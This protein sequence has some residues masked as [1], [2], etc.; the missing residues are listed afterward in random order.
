MRIIK[1]AD[2]NEVSKKAAEI[3]RSQVILKPESVLGL[4]TGSTPLGMYEELVSAVKK[5]ELDFSKVTTFNLD[6]Y[7]PIAPENEQS[8]HYYMKNNFFDG[9]KIRPE[10]IHMPPG[11]TDCPD[12][13]CKLMT[14]QLKMPAELTFKFSASVKTAI[15]ALMSRVSIYIPAPTLSSLRKT[16]LRQIHASLKMRT[17]CPAVQSQWVSAPL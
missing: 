1:C 7:Y 10:S 8:Y 5:G 9:A 17:K 3:V 2:Y 4:A 15:S 13:D 16:Q 12:E 11:M 14:G 6:E